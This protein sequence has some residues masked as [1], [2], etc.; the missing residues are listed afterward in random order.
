[1][2]FAVFSQK[3]DLDFDF[4]AQSLRGRSTLTIEPKLPDLKTIRI[5]SRQCR[6]RGV[7]VEGKPAAFS[8]RDPYSSLHLYPKMTVHQHHILKDRLEENV[9][10]NA[11]QPEDSLEIIIPTGVKIQPQALLPVPVQTRQVNGNNDADDDTADA[12]ALKSAVDAQVSY[13][14]LQVGIEFEVRHF[15]DGLHFVGLESGDERYPHLYTCN[16]DFPGSACS[17]FPCVD[18]ATTKH[19]WD[20]SIRYPR[21]LGE[22]MHKPILSSSV[23]GHPDSGEDLANTSKRDRSED[24]ITPLNQEDKAL[25]MRVVCSGN[26]TDDVADQNDPTRKIATFRIDDPVAARHVGF[27][28]GPFE[29]IDLSEYR[30]SDQD[31]KLGTHAVRVHGF[32]LP[33]RASEVRNTCMPLAAAVDFFS[34]NYVAYP[35]PNHKVLFVDDLAPSVADSASLSICSTRLLIPEDILD[36]LYDA[37][38]ELLRGLAAQWVGVLVFPRNPQDFWITIGGAHFMAD[39][40]GAQLW[41]KN[42]QRYRLKL[43]ANQVI[44]QDVRRP[45]LHDLGYHIADIPGWLDFMKLKSPVVLQ[46]LHQRLIKSSGRNGVNRILWRVLTNTKTEAMADG[47][48]STPAFARTCE[49]VGH[50][51]LDVFFNQ[52]IYG[53]GYPIFLINQKFNKKK[54]CVEMLIKQTQSEQP[55]ADSGVPLNQAQLKERISAENLRRSAKEDQAGIIPSEV[56]RVFNGPMTIRIHEADGTP[57]EHIVEIKDAVTRIDIP[58]NT[59]Y[60][61]LKRSKRQKE[62]Q[63]ANAAAN[64]GADGQDETLLYCLGDVLQTEV[65][66]REWRLQDWPEEEETKMGQ[67]SYE[68]IRVDKDFEW[69]SKT[70]FIQPGYMYVSQLQQ[71]NDVVAQIE[72][73]WT[74]TRLRIILC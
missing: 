21:T 46:I 58:Y 33:G 37:T 12:P 13:S 19:E 18:S 9:Y 22:A 55:N 14:M 3:L 4:V 62:R 29:H 39:Q 63:Q 52:W 8:Y 31:E 17:I 34:T 30:E 54:L 65:E 6:I 43:A 64:P 53:S 51:K 67:E 69:I 68:W 66:F 11:S 15:R 73:S 41:G 70:Y 23:D 10:L 40:F 71:D 35:Y 2:E 36:P 16:S 44:D 26:L 60:K 59:K 32:C 50:T 42:E 57:Y 49:K 74:S 7:T 38:R 48:I 61:R 28:I 27:A 25:E 56:Q 1:M 47:A 20:I 24:Y 72:V 5:N 45:S